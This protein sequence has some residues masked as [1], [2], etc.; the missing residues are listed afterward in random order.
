[1]SNT[2]YE[3]L[4]SEEFLRKPEVTKVLEYENEIRIDQMKRDFKTVKENYVT[5]ISYEVPSRD[6]EG[7]DLRTSIKIGV[8]PPQG[9]IHII[10]V[11]IVLLTIRDIQQQILR[12]DRFFSKGEG[13]PGQ[14]SPPKVLSAQWLRFRSAEQRISLQ[15]K[16]QW[17]LSWCRK[18][19]TSTFWPLGS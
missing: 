1:M 3:L 16:K 11:V 8:S 5:K 9:E 18:A 4:H 12:T 17:L 10:I 2:S 13:I 14:A 19:Y 7:Q 6:L 15:K